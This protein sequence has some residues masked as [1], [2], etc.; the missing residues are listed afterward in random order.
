MIKATSTVC[1]ELVGAR[2]MTPEELDE[3]DIFRWS[4]RVASAVYYA[5]ENLR[6]GAP[7]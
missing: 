1:E 4:Y 2:G 7:S 3:R 5:V 6:R